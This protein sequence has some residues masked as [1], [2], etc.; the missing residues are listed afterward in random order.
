[1]PFFGKKKTKTS[2]SKADQAEDAQ[3]A[4]T[5][6][7][8]SEAPKSV[9]EPTKVA[10]AEEKK[11]KATEPAPQA[12]KEQQAPAAGGAAMGP[13]PKDLAF[14]VQLA[15][16]SGTKK[17]NDFATVKQLY[18]RIAQEFSI[19]QKD[20]FFCTLGTDRVDTDRL[21]GGQIGLNDVIFVHV[22][23]EEK[24]V[25]VHKRE[26]AL[27]LTITDNGAGCAFIKRIKDG[28]ISSEVAEICV[29]DHIAEVNGR[30][31]FGV[32]HIEVAKLLKDMPV[33]E[34][35]TLKLYS[36]MKTP[37]NGIAPR[38]T[39]N[40]LSTS[41]TELGTGK[42]TLRLKATGQATVQTVDET[43]WTVKAAEAVDDC[44]ESFMGIRDNELAETAVDA[45]KASSGLEEFRSKIDED[46]EVFGFPE[47]FVEEMWSSIQKIKEEA[48]K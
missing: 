25:T 28:S 8:A 30:E 41:N 46:L 37:F 38:N 1:M 44:L 27:G 15:H 7:A 26:A 40:T 12:Q 6:A 5:A 10:E 29:G 9:E 31:L 17:V 42:Q 20:L 43:S 18:T 16:G 23:G 36:P 21:L 2:V 3:A 14:P 32:R 22:R 35:F 33:G 19:E 45:A 39:K 4:T 34:D 13:P 48:T 47:S 24:H 11:P